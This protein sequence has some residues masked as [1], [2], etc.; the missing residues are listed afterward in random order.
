MS[1]APLVVDGKVILGASGGEVGVRGFVAAVD[2]ETGKALWKTY[3][4]PAPGEPGSDT[5]P[6]AAITTSAAAAPS[7]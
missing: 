1:L 4:V 6:R 2:A 5:W 7:G 3:T